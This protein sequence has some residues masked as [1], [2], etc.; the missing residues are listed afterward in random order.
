MRQK[1][2][3]DTYKSLAYLDPIVVS[4]CYDQSSFN[5]MIKKHI[6][7][8]NDENKC[9]LF[10]H[11]VIS[12]HLFFRRKSEKVRSLSF[13]ETEMTKIKK[14][15]SALIWWHK[16]LEKN[17]ELL[18]D[19]FVKNKIKIK[20]RDFFNL[21]INEKWIDNVSFKKLNF[22]DI[23]ALSE[24]KYFQRVYL[25][26]VNENISASK[27]LTADDLHKNDIDYFTYSIISPIRGDDRFPRIMNSM[28]KTLF[29]EHINFDNSSSRKRMLNFVLICYI[30]FYFDRNLSPLSISELKTDIFCGHDSECQFKLFEFV[31]KCWNLVSHE[32][33]EM[34]DH[35]LNNGIGRNYILD[36]SSIYSEYDDRF[37]TGRNANGEIFEIGHKAVNLFMYEKFEEPY[38]K[39]EST[40]FINAQIIDVMGIH[41]KIDSDISDPFLK[42]MILLFEKN[43]YYYKNLPILNEFFDPNL[44]LPSQEAVKLLL[45][46]KYNEFVNYFKSFIKRNRNTCYIRLYGDP[47]I[48]KN[49]TFYVWI[50]PIKKKDLFDPTLKRGDLISHDHNLYSSNKIC[51]NSGAFCEVKAIENNQLDDFEIGFKL[52]DIDNDFKSIDGMIKMNIYDENHELL[53]YN[54]PASSTISNQSDSDNFY[55]MYKDDLLPYIRDTLKLNNE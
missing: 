34:L 3:K 29:W 36:G 47:I 5:Y 48:V 2:Q 6:I 15:P 17:D 46:K 9:F 30:K 11:P 24:K 54:D 26:Y 28:K 33:M 1:K 21:S 7:Q 42:F 35:Y 10:S 32:K 14:A 22:N 49:S 55:E 23:S 44:E 20:V 25:E 31:K 40:D 37:N 50:Y 45:E 38:N 51:F 53:K 13:T 4:Q 16:Q 39:I 18:I 52:D 19:F 8:W 27:E 41:K 43:V 12:A